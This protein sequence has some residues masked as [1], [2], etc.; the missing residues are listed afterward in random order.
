M[1]NIVM[2]TCFYGNTASACVWNAEKRLLGR[3]ARTWN[4]YNQARTQI[5]Q[6]L[7]HKHKKTQIYTNELA[8][9]RLQIVGHLKC[10]SC[11]LKSIGLHWWLVQL[12]A[13]KRALQSCKHS[14]IAAWLR[15]CYGG[16]A[17]RCEIHYDT[18]ALHRLHTYKSIGIHTQAYTQTCSQRDSYTCT[19]RHTTTPIASAVF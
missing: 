9:S 15:S 14:I 8:I 12:E 2:A 16:L 7:F 5:Y 17:A 13:C 4:T 1:S 6:F 3:I 11:N 18:V 10:I 19:Q